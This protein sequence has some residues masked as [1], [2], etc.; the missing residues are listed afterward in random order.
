MWSDVKGGYLGAYAKG[1]ATSP[2]LYQVAEEAV[3]ALP[4]VLGGL[5]LKAAWLYKY[6]GSLT[7][8]LYL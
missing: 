7:R 3:A 8:A 2:L 5:V 6:E 4:G 1:S